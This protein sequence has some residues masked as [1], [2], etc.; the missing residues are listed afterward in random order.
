[1]TTG[2]V[3]FAQN[4]S[5][6]DYVKL[7]VFA[8][9]RIKQYLDIPVSLI[10]D[11]KDWL[12]KIY[13]DHPFD[14][15]IDIDFGIFQ[16]KK[17]YDGAL[18]SKNVEWKNFTRDKIYALTPY[19]RTLVVD[20]DYI[21]NSS[22]IKAAFDNDNDFQIYRHSMDLAEWRDIKEFTRINQYSIPFYWATAF[23]FQKNYITETFFDLVA[24][25]K[26]EWTYFRTLYEIESSTFRNDFAFSIAIHIMNGKI[27]G[28]FAVDL[29]G[30]MTFVKDRDLLVNMDGNKMKFL[31]EKKDYAGQY[32][33]VKTTGLDIH[34]MNKISLS[35]YIDGGSGV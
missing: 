12:N 16:Y 31:V 15:I 34:V 24:Y 33:L 5:S 11:S 9:K 27:N 10:T 20:S 28:E 25:I 23:V 30:R 19:D 1:M 22:V 3:I 21:I 6:L 8:A 17:F 4:N 7:S 14:Q 32:T 18:S 29:P 2:A 35:R 13:P 26:T